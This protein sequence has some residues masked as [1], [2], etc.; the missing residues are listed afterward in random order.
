MKTGYNI[1]EAKANLEH[2]LE[3]VEGGRPQIIK[4]RNKEVVI[5]VSVD[6]FRKRFGNDPVIRRMTEEKVVK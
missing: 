3:L 5:V 2:I 1:T 6:D 4:R